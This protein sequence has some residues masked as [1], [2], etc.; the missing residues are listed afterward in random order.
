MPPPARPPA[1]TSRFLSLR[2]EAACLQ[3]SEENID[4]QQRSSKQYSFRQ[5]IKRLSW[6]Y[7]FCFFCFFFSLSLELNAHAKHAVIQHVDWRIFNDGCR[8][9]IQ[10]TKQ[11]K[12]FLCFQVGRAKQYWTDGHKMCKFY[13]TNPSPLRRPQVGLSVSNYWNLL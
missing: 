7:F 13:I 10:K 8:L 9:F 2:W 5:S 4:W 1:P 12:A 6:V 3:L 11:N